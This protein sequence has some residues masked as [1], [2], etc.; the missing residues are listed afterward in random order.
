MWMTA[1]TSSGQ[2]QRECRQRSGEWIR[3]VE[4]IGSTGAPRLS[5]VEEGTEHTA[6]L[7]YSIAHDIDAGH[8]SMRIM[9]YCLNRKRSQH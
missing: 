8:L 6:T 3:W 9:V 7:G 2:Q 4:A 5:E 1:L